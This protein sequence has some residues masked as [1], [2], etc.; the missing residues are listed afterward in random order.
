MTRSM[1][2]VITAF[3]VISCQSKSGEFSY[4]TTVS[5]DDELNEADV[6]MGA[7]KLNIGTHANSSVVLEADFSKEEWKPEMN[8]DRSL[9]S[10][11][12]RQPDGK[13]NSMNDEDYN[14]WQIKLPTELDS[15]LSIAMGAGEGKINLSGAKLKN[16]KFEAG[17]GDFDINL[18][19]AVLSALE[20][21]A[22]VGQI[23]L[24]LS[25]DRKNNLRAQI[26][27]GVG[28]INL[29]LPRGTGVRIKVNGLGGVD[30]NEFIKRDGYFVNDQYGKTSESIEVEINGGLGSLELMLK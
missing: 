4:S 20:V 28:A 17:A 9:G 22:G 25:G 13:F 18:A 1:V 24:D 6:A 12:I 29:T 8:L 26:N 16:V 30:Q 10:L 14:D 21:N 27:G 15:D 11:T 2:L 7:G 23:K 19:G 3:L 5:L